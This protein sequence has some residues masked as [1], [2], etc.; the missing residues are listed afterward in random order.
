MASA[1]SQI[2]GII[3]ETYEKNIFLHINYKKPYFFAEYEYKFTK[4]PLLLA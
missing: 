4:K 3:G 2:I 1:F